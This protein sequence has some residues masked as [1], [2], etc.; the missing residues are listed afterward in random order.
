M[1][2]RDQ[3][4]FPELSLSTDSPPLGTVQAWL[5]VL[6]CVLLARGHPHVLVGIIDG[7]GSLSKGFGHRRKVLLADVTMCIN[8]I[9][10][11]GNARSSL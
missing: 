5:I 4:A 9:K 10:D 2:Y 7:F 11:F 1:R 3:P 8:L 6:M